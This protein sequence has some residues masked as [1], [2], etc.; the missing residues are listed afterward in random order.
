LLSSS[1]KDSAEAA[2]VAQHKCE[3]RA[4]V[5]HALE[6]RFTKHFIFSCLQRWKIPRVRKFQVSKLLA[7]IVKAVH[8]QWLD[9]LAVIGQLFQETPMRCL[10]PL[11]FL[12][13]IQ[14][15]IREEVEYSQRGW[16]MCETNQD[17]RIRI[18]FDKCFN[19]LLG[20]SRIYEE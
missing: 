3:R 11:F 10:L 18:I 2:N 14:C 1:V 8:Y 6:L 9:H 5:S 4:R 12:P 17:I 7:I 16:I 20:G 15:A 13:V 19:R